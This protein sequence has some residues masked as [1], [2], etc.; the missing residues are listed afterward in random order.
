VDGS[1][2]DEGAVIW[3]VATDPDGYLDN[4]TI[5]KGSTTHHAIEFGDT[6]PSS[7][8]LRNCTFSGYSANDNQYDSTFYFADTTGTITLNLVGCS[9]N[10]KVKTAGCTVNVVEDPVTVKVIVKNSAGTVIE[11]ARVMVRAKDGTGPFPYQETV[12][13]SNSGTTA[14][15][16]HTGH[17]M[18]TN[19]IVDIK[20]ASH[21][22]NNGIHQITLDGGDPTNKYTYTLTS[23]PGSSPTG[24]IT[25]TFVALYGLS[26]ALGIVSTSRVYSSNQ[27]VTGWAR[28]STSTPL[29]KTGL[30]DDE[31]NSSGG[32]NATAILIADE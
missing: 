3:D 32:L 14:T 28:K 7:L 31:V 17:G 10:V 18:A 24:T 2:T 16:T 26:N 21:W 20:G 5:T 13:I 19:D 4:L 12:T 29:Y 23:D 22:Q 15:V 9:G 6:V 11:N 8:T 27:P 30:V 1:S 25:S